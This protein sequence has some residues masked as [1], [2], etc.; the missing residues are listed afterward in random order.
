M[1]G[2]NSIKQLFRRPVF[3]LLFILLLALSSA[4]LCVCAG[5]WANARETQ[6]RAEE[7][8]TTIAVLNDGPYITSE[9]GRAQRAAIRAA[10]EASPHVRLV[11]DRQSLY[12]SAEAIWG[13]WDAEESFNNTPYC[14]GFIFGECTYAGPQTL[15][16]IGG[17]D[18]Y[19]AVFALDREAST[20]L[21]PE[22]DGVDTVIVITSIYS[23]PG[24]YLFEVGKRYA[25]SVEG[26]TRFSQANVKADS[27]GRENT[28]IGWYEDGGND[29]FFAGLPLI[30]N[31][32][33]RSDPERDE[34]PW[35]LRALYGDDYMPT[36]YNDDGIYPSAYYYYDPETLEIFRLSHINYDRYIGDEYCSYPS[37]LLT[38]GER[39]KWFPYAEVDAETG[40]A[41]L[42]ATEYGFV[43]ERLA[44]QYDMS[45]HSFL[46]FKTDCLSS[47]YQFNQQKNE[48]IEGRAF[49]EEEYASGAPVCVVSAAFAAQNG[50]AVGDVIG[51]ISLY[52]R[53][54]HMGGMNK[55]TPLYPNEYSHIIEDVGQLD[56]K[57]LSLEIV[58]IYAGEN[59]ELLNSFSFSENTVFVPAK[60]IPGEY[61]ALMNWNEESRYTAFFDQAAE[62]PGMYSLVLRNGS[63]EAFEA[64]ME[65]A[66]YGGVFHYFDQGYSNVAGAL[67][68]LAKNARIFLI[69][70]ALVWVASLGLFL[71]LYA[72]QAR[73]ELGIMALLGAGRKRMFVHAFAAAALVALLATALGLGAGLASY[74]AAAEAVL[75]AAEEAEEAEEVAVLGSGGADLSAG[76]APAVS[77]TALPAAAAV[78]LGVLLLVIACASAALAKKPPLA[79]A[80]GAGKGK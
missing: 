30:Y 38:F 32:Q 3:L 73:R 34:D 50:L 24:K 2:K 31:E 43:W 64:E 33:A 66:G 4:F 59:W 11:D 76:F 75:S 54:F 57:A 29:W 12:G 71:A 47:V 20:P 42:C 63:V 36:P 22:F 53:G 9:E 67:A 48:I 39:A 72:R 8:F 77:R 10:A 26:M 46:I 1:T 61:P 19:E 74:D 16:G 62:R 78:Q 60:A 79:L 49:T 58:G 80:Q 23:E 35:G 40:L 45:H 37:I 15:Q 5:L 6:R 55:V 68:G 52:N 41:D 65:E 13:V 14:S 70:S 25:L 44:R 27:A 56:E 28:V 21:H 17:G 18:C 7:T 69:V 51:N